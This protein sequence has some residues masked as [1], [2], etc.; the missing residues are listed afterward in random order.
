MTNKEDVNQKISSKFYFKL[1]LRT[2]LFLFFIV[3]V[4]VLLD[5]NLYFCR[6]KE[7]LEY[8]VETFNLPIKLLGLTFITTGAAFTYY[9]IESTH[10]Q[11]ER[12]IEQHIKAN[13]TS[14]RA[15][16]FEL[17]SEQD[18]EFKA[19][20]IP[21]SWLFNALYPNAKNGDYQLS[22]KF[23]E[24]IT[25]EENGQGFTGSLNGLQE[26]LRAHDERKYKAHTYFQLG[27]F[28]MELR[29]LL[30][31]YEADVNIS[32]TSG[33][34]FNE[35]VAED[36]INITND[37]FYIVSTINAFEGWRFFDN[38]QRRQWKGSIDSLEKVKQTCEDISEFINSDNAGICF[39]ELRRNDIEEFNKRHMRNELPENLKDNDAAKKYIFESLNTFSLEAEAKEALANALNITK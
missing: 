26:I 36:I 20:H 37:T 10:K 1:A 16:F 31:L 15:D 39:N 32:S 5:S 3:T 35:R 2:P 25:W 6:T 8:F 14:L 29:T 33:D 24:F 38:E 27:T 30:N 7:C 17:L 12:Q 19:I 11:N 28:I 22:P 34:L 18:Y 13:Y 23:E 4:F 9:R 21:Q